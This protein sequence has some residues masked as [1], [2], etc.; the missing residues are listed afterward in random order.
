M[1][2]GLA[3]SST[4]S[5]PLSPA[6]V[7]PVPGFRTCD[8]LDVVTMSVVF[9]GVA[10]LVGDLEEAMSECMGDVL[11]GASIG[12]GPEGVSTSSGL[13]LGGSDER[14]GGSNELGMG[15]SSEMGLLLSLLTSCVL[16]FTGAP[17]LGGEVVGTVG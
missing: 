17:V 10:W 3:G 12:G 5:S 6:S 15:V 8:S 4:R 7:S 14:S 11:D 13:P 9:S 2:P 16:S 1:T